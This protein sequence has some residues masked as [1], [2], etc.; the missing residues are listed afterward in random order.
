M[1]ER[2]D[3]D[4]RCLNGRGVFFGY[5]KEGSIE[6]RLRIWDSKLGF[7]EVLR[8]LTGELTLFSKNWGNHGRNKQ[9]VSETG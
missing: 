4:P 1:K 8:R 6:R 7:E 9:N 2:G 3:N 5:S